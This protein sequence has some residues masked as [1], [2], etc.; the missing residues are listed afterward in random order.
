M[1]EGIEEKR[2]E[3]AEKEI[4]RVAKAL[5]DYAASVDRAAEEL[6]KE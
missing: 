1:R 4:G 2:Y 6:E 3:E 5:N